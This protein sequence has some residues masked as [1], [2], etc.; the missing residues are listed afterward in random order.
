MPQE[1]PV[2]FANQDAK[3]RIRQA[4]DIVDLIGGYM[5]LRRQGRNFVGTCPWHDDTRPSLNVNQ[6]RQSWKCWVCNIGGDIFSFL[7]QREGVDFREALQML[8][9]RA[10]ITLASSG[11]PKTKP[12][13]PNDKK[14]LYE[15]MAWAEKLFR[16]CLRSSP[17]AEVARRY[18]ADRKLTQQTVD[19]FQLGFAPDS[20][21]WLLDHA[22]TTSFSP[23]VL[24]AVGLVKKKDEAN[25]YYDFFRG[26][27]IF[28]IRDAQSRPI[29]IGGRVLPNSTNPAKY[30]NTETTRLFSKSDQVYALDLARDA[31]A[32][33]K[34]VVV[35][36]GYMDVIMCH[37]NGLKNVVAVLGTA[38]GPKHISL[39][40]RY[41]ERITLVLDGDEAGKRRTNEVLELFVASEVDLR[42][43]TLPDELDPCEF[44]EERPAEELRD[45]LANAHDAFEHAISV[46]TQGIDFVRDTHRANQGLERLLGIIA[47]APRFTNESSTSKLLRERQVVA[48]LARDFRVEETLLRQR[49]AE[50]RQ[51]SPAPRPAQSQVVTPDLSLSVK[52]M[53]PLDAELFEILVRHPELVDV[54][55][56]ELTPE[57]LSPG[58]ARHLLATYRSIAERGETADFLHVLDELE[59]FSPQEGIEPTRQSASH[60]EGP[61]KSSVAHL[62]SL[63]VELDERAS[64]KEARAHADAATRLRRL[65][66]DMQYRFQASDRRQQLATLE[67]KRLDGAEELNLLHHLVEQE[68]R[69]Q[70][71]PAPT[72]G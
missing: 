46:E 22:R 48:R 64:L 67:Q 4:I 65:I 15:C 14:T 57:H 7:M 44:L 19:T 51:N 38:L 26:R 36:E 53:Q 25:R 33:A 23:A 3:D 17:E 49:L 69:R 43:A 11:G 40:R 62:K 1:S 54:V 66:E 41:S 39:L 60:G 2:S 70:G 59:E 24:H 58:P 28:P 30:I 32:A 8:A 16:D 47:R 63:L 56:T 6:E 9:D 50:L 27:V 34:N 71:I 18:I 61:S 20:W 29:A 52:D 72:D 42:I 37:Q 55:L 5:P 21:Q 10:G 13:D 68:R 45:L 31:I 12:G 35:V